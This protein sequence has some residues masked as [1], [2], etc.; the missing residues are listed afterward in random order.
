[1]RDLIVFGGGALPW[2]ADYVAWLVCGSAA[3]A[4]QALLRGPPAAMRP[5]HG[6]PVE[7]RGE[8]A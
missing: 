3:I 8:T 1:M 4:V 7:S 6:E 2:I 5:V